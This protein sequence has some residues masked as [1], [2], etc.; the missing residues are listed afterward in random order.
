MQKPHDCNDYS[1]ILKYREREGRFPVTE[2]AAHATSAP[3][4]RSGRPWGRRG[5]VPWRGGRGLGAWE[6]PAQG[7]CPRALRCCVGLPAAPALLSQEV[8]LDREPH[9]PAGRCLHA[10]P[11]RE[12]CV[13]FKTG[14]KFARSRKRSPDLTL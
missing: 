1:E 14:S 10:F 3:A 4:F 13:R 2:A 5:T 7:A 8:T 12:K 9:A 11:P 6:P